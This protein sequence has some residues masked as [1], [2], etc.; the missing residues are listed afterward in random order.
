MPV[1]LQKR[2]DDRFPILI[3]QLDAVAQSF[4]VRPA[5]I[6]RP[7][8]DQRAPQVRLPV[9]N[10]AVFHRY[11]KQGQADDE[12]ADKRMFTAGHTPGAYEVR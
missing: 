1:R 12:R 9:S 8:R 10:F 5:E 11:S 2:R 3:R 6:F 7:H 4:V